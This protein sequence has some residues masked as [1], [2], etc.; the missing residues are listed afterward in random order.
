[1]KNNL[2][3]LAIIIIQVVLYIIYGLLIG[4]IV[5]TLWDV[6]M[7]EVM[8]GVGCIMMAIGLIRFFNQRT[9]VPIDTVLMYN[10]GARRFEHFMGV[11]TDLDPDMET[12]GSLFTPKSM[13]SFLFKRHYLQLIV[14][15]G[16]LIGIVMLSYRDYFL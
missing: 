10:N 7:L 13:M 16:M 8:F 15:G 12:T 3:L 2:T 14:S 4:L 11:N 6:G 9:A 1:M 5:T